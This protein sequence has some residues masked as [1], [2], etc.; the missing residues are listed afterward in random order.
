MI[1]IIVNTY[2]SN[3]R[4]DVAVQS[5]IHMQKLFLDKIRIHN[6][7]FEDEKLDFINP[8]PS[9][10]PVFVLS[11]STAVIKGASKKLPFFSELYEYGL[12]LDGDHFIVINNDVIINKIC[13]DTI[14]E[15]KPQAYVCSR[16]DIRQPVNG[17]QSIVDRQLEPLDFYC[18]GFDLFCFNRLW[19]L[20]NQQHLAQKFVL[21]KAVWDI[22]VA[23]YTKCFGGN[24][25]IG[26]DYPPPIFHIAHDSNSIVEDCPER[27]WNLEIADSRPLN[28]MMFNL[29][30][31]NFKTNLINRMPK[32][33]FQNLADKE[34]EK[35]RDFFDYMRMDRDFV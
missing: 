2:K 16:F 3:P 12:K 10:E 20:A 32:N 29:M 13:V 21:G 18:A 9:L 35:E 34:K 1:D 30:D 31:Y 17:Y 24:F 7:Q 8:Y 4:Q 26:N 11:D 6:L 28:K 23:G 5:W 27:Q 19:A 33:T 14:L 25:P 15:K 22:V